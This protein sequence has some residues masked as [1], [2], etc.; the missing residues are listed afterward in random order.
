MGKIHIVEQSDEPFKDRIEAGRLLAD[1]L[2]KYRGPDTII[3]GIPRGG[4]IIAN[5]VARALDAGLD[6]VLS[7]KLGA[8]GNPELAVGAISEDGKLFLN[9]LIMIEGSSDSPYI[10]HEKEHQMQEIARRVEVFRKARPK[11]ILK[12]KTVIVTDDGLATGATMQ[13][14]LWMARH[15]GP[16]KLISAVPV[17]PADTIEKISADA[18]ELIVLR[19]P[20]FFGAVGQFYRYFDQTGDDEVLKI[21]QDAYRRML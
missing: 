3:L 21:L 20:Q 14:A 8:P 7:R 5:E 15:E 13:A 19:V 16:K 11:A 17:A 2:K 12:G 18:D 10:K 4:V 9:D 6:I 1:E